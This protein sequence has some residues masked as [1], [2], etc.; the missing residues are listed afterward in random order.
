MI[1]FHK[2]Q[3]FTCSSFDGVTP[4]FDVEFVTAG[5]RLR[6]KRIGLVSLVGVVGFD[7]TNKRG[8]EQGNVMS[9]TVLSKMRIVSNN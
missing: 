1:F 9:I 6:F 3:L 8:A 4:V 2:T 5:K 7:G